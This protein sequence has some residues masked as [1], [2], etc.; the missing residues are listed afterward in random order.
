M[1]EHEA[2]HPGIDTTDEVKAELAAYQQDA[3]RGRRSK[4]SSTS[5]AACWAFLPR[6]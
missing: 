1:N 4:L 3:R 6:R 2:H 5:T